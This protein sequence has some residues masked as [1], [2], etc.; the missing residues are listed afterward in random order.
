[1]AKNVVARKG[2]TLSVEVYTSDDVTVT[3]NGQAVA[4]QPPL[5]IAKMKAI[6][7]WEEEPSDGAWKGKD[8]KFRD[9]LGKKVR[10]K[11]V[12]A[13]RPLRIGMADRYSK[14]FL[15]GK[16][17]FNGETFIIDA[18]GQFQDGQHRGVGLVLAEQVRDKD[19]KKWSDYIG[20]KPI[21][22]DAII[23]RGV[24]SKADTIDTLNIGQ[25]RSLGDVIYRDHTL[26]DARKG[27]FTDKELISLSNT[28]AV[29]LRL[30]W[31]RVVGKSVSDAPHF[32]HS[33]ALDFL[34]AHKGIVSCVLEI[35][36]IE[37]DDKCITNHITMG[38]ASGL[39][40]LMS[41]AKTSPELFVEQGAAALD[42]SLGERAQEFWD[43]FGG[44]KLPAG[45][46]ISRAREI[47]KALESGSASGREEV[48]RTILKAWNLWVDGKTSVTRDD[49]AIQKVM[50]E[51]KG[52]LV[53][54]ESPRVGGIDTDWSLYNLEL[55]TGDEDEEEGSSLKDKNSQWEN[56][57]EVNEEGE[58]VIVRRKKAGLKG[59]GKKGKK[60]KQH[61]SGWSVGDTCWVK[62]GDIAWFGT[63]A[64]LHDD[65]A[66][67]KSDDDGNLY[68]AA[69]KELHTDEPK[70]SL[71]EEDDPSGD[72]FGEDDGGDGA[73]EAANELDP[74]PEDSEDEE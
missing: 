54:S 58:E 52:M 56:V 16:W 25:K 4:P 12:K 55:V 1:M 14:E 33:E 53:M 7:G 62:E 61:P 68:T 66:D 41:A 29:A 18:N 10:L 38:Y 20:E 70:D 28:L 60:P 13:N 17:K 9:K 15:R 6:L 8:F 72:T 67:V 50:N 34:R 37:G 48:I 36:D 31:L 51:E 24:S 46:P 57:T 30:V 64:E 5:D 69:I 74:T 63:I 19:P 49:V 11:N 71:A 26:S 43:L 73:A 3:V 47:L 21:T 22:L 65:S 40:Y 59:K 35:S 27:A 42:F 44:T 23:V 39:M 45:N 32:P 2:R